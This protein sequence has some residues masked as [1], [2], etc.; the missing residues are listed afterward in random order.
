[1]P[2]ACHLQRP[3]ENRAYR[4]VQCS[5]V[6]YGTATVRCSS[7]P[8][9]PASSRSCSYCCCCSCSPTSPRASAGSASACGQLPR[10][11]IFRM[12]LLVRPRPRRS[13]PHLEG[14]S[15]SQRDG[16]RCGPVAPIGPSGVG[17]R[18]SGVERRGIQYRTTVLCWRGREAAGS[19]ST[20]IQKQSDDC[21]PSWQL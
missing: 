9:R 14:C 16:C 2:T 6:R 7:T 18:E 21:T 1:M 17:S 11:H 20:H 4:T 3:S 8:P 15:S 13:R 12:A 10:R 19:V 5:T